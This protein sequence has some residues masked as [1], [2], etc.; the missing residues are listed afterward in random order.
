MNAIEDHEYADSGHDDV[1]ENNCNCWRMPDEIVVPLHGEGT[2]NNIAPSIAN[3]DDQL[4]NNNAM[5]DV[6]PRSFPQST[7]R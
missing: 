7:G 1:Q 5:E 4:R 3:N 6:P 2:V